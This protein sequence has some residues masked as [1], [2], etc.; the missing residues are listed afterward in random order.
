MDDIRSLLFGKI[1]FLNNKE[2]VAR[3]VNVHFRTL[4]TQCHTP[5]GGKKKASKKE[6]AQFFG[7]LKEFWEVKKVTSGTR[8]GQ[9]TKALLALGLLLE[10]SCTSG[11]RPRTGQTH[12]LVSTEGAQHP[13]QGPR[14]S[15]GLRSA[16]K[17]EVVFLRIP[18]KYL[19]METTRFSQKKMFFKKELMLNVRSENI[20]IS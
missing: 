18:E 2:R 5:G 17:I 7:G 3:D 16:G 20:E 15:G 14:P 12:Q 9:S 6:K 1:P 8:R 13:Q 10:H 11:D 4:F 19:K